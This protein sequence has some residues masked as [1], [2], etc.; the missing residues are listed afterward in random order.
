MYHSRLPLLLAVLAVRAGAQGLP[1][2][3][4][5]AKAR[6][7]TSDIPNFWRVFDRA[8]LRD[9]AELFQRE[10][11]DAGS[12]GLHGFIPARIVSGRALAAT[13]AARPRYFAAIRQNTLS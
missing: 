6:I 2:N 12:P 11:I 4:D 1:P 8:T 10:Y 7:V 5:P 3:H 9:A 13:V